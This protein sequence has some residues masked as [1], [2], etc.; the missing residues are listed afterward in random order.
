MNIA[1]R[2]NDNVWKFSIYKLEKKSSIIILDLTKFGQRVL[3]DFFMGG[4]VT[5]F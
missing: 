4:G 2:P 3:F 5:F 1:R